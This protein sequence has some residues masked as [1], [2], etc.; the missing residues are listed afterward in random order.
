MVLHAIRRLRYMGLSSHDGASGYD[1][2][3]IVS[4]AVERLLNGIRT[5]TEKDFGDFPN[6]FKGIINSLIYSLKVSKGNKLKD[7]RDLTGPLADEVFF[8]KIIDEQ[9]IDENE[10][11]VLQKT[12]EEELLKKDDDMFL[13]YSELC[14]GKKHKEIAS[15][16]GKS[17]GDVENIHKRLDTFIKNYRAKQPKN[18]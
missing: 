14:Q 9:L 17:V 12:F 8:E 4:L 6:Y 3:N 15:S 13:V 5:P 16:L 2:C 18:G 7:L 1:P 11:F 10:L